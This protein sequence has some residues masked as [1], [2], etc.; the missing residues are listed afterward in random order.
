MTEID[1]YKEYKKKILKFLFAN[2]EEQSILFRELI[3]SELN[4]KKKN[5]EESVSSKDPILK[6]MT[7]KLNENIHKSKLK[8]IE[9]QTNILKEQMIAYSNNIKHPSH[10]SIIERKLF[11]VELQID[12]G[13]YN[14][15]NNKTVEFIFKT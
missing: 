12:V 14:L 1:S 15:L 2:P 10:I 8:D 9:C 13:I 3:D 7:D 5:I 6:E 11:I 4:R